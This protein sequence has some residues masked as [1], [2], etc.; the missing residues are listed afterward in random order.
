MLVWCLHKMVILELNS[1]CRTKIN[2][3]SVALKGAVAHGRVPSQKIAQ[4]SLNN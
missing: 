1:I 3:M 4:L 2:I